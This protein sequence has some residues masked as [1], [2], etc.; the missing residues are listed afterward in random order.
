MFTDRDLH[1]FWSRVPQG[2][3]EQ[4]WVWEG[5]RNPQGYGTF[6]LNCGQIMAH[7]YS[8]ALKLGRP[9]EHPMMACHTC[10]NPGC[11]NPNHLWEGTRS[12]N[13]RDA[14]T[15][16]RMPT[17]LPPAESHPRGEGHPFAKL[18]EEKV[19]AIRASN[20]P[21]S[22]WARQYGVTTTMIHNVRSRKNWAHVV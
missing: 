2:D 7:R 12:D 22:F 14:I 17:K 4:C 21:A 11:V 15:K 20:E 10:D 19:R 3:P 9:I 13:V 16:G 5:F 8:L 1:R 18:D 6:P